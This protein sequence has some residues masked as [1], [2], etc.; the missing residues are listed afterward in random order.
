MELIRNFPRQPQAPTVASLGNFDGVHLGHQA[1]A[2]ILKTCAA[3][4]RL[5]STVIVFEPQPQEYFSS[6]TVAPRLTSLREK[7]QA[8]EALG[9]D[10]LICLRFDDVLANLAAPEFV[11]TI[12]VDRLKVRH[13]AVGDDF[14]FGKAREG[15]S[16]MLRHM[17]SELG[18][19]L[20]EVPRARWL[21]NG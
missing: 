20:V 1:I 5:P 7:Y 2:K 19:Q 13:L 16:R 10:R 21:G 4:Y 8:F 18:F 12:L 14:R 6:H 3:R 11:Q 9:I 15:D 17:A